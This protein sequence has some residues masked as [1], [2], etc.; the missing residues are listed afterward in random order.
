MRI[1]IE[2]WYFATSH[3]WQHF[4]LGYFIPTKH[5]KPAP[6]S[7][8]KICQKITYT[9]RLFFE[10]VVIVFNWN[11][12]ACISLSS[13]NSTHTT[14]SSEVTDQ[15]WTRSS[16]APRVTAVYARSRFNPTKHPDSVPFTPLARELPLHQP[17]PE[18]VLLTG[19]SE[20]PL[21]RA[22]I[23]QDNASSGTATPIPATVEGWKSSYFD[24]ENGNQIKNSIRSP[25]P[26][27]WHHCLGPITSINTDV[28]SVHHKSTD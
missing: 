22:E 21:P 23:R 3:F 16:Y 25:P 20:V 7:T 15:R 17:L 9:A 18:L 12:F 27:Q 1:N 10:R 4:K 11:K 5:I 26:T 13:V 19:W 6:L 24:A 2:A 28:L 14:R 8:F